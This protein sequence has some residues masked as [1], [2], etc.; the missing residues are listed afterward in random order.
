MNIKF[1]RVAGV[2]SRQPSVVAI[3][4]NLRVKWNLRGWTCDCEDWQFGETGDSCAHV[5]AVADL[6]EPRVTQEQQ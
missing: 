2:R 6:L 4:D 5:D 1:L 3:V